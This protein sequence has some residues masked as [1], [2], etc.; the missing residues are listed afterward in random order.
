MRHLAKFIWISAAVGFCGT[1][2]AQQLGQSTGDY[3][4]DL[5]AI[6]GA[7]QAVRLIKEICSEDFP[8]TKLANE[9]LYADWRTKNLKFLQEVERHMNKAV[10]DEAKAS[11]KAA[12]ETVSALNRA[13]RAFKATQRKDMAAD[14]VATY[15]VRCNSY[16]ALSK[17]QQWDLESSMAEEVAAMRKG[18]TK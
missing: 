3:A 17:S 13:M 10:S 6:Y 12:T 7:S 16:G 8:E 9:R 2:G 18:P 15:R 1:S 4:I 5:N 14:G 11:P